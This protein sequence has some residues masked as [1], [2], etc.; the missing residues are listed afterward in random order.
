[1]LRGVQGIFIC[2]GQKTPEKALGV[3]SPFPS[4]LLMYLVYFIFLCFSPLPWSYRNHP[5][6]REDCYTKKVGL[7]QTP[8]LLWLSLPTKICF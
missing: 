5:T 2:S 4:F 7:F 1:F 3:V 8:V 6:Y